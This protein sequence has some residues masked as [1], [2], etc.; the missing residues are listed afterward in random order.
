MKKIFIILAAVAMLASCKSDFLDKSPLDKLSEDAVFNSPELAEAYVNALYTV[1]P[2]PFQEGNISCITD[3]GYFRY[4]GSATRWRYD[5]RL[6]PDN[7]MYSEEGG[8]AHNTRTTVLNI[9]NR[10]YQYIYRMNSYIK[11]MNETG[12]SMRVCLSLRSLRTFRT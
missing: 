9:W 2:D 6:N 5:G 3:E 4:G 11:Y 10:A 7:V 8:Y 1:L 12:S